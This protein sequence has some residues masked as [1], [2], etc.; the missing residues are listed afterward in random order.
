MVFIR[1]PE[2]VRQYEVNIFWFWREVLLHGD[3]EL[4]KENL[5]N[6]FLLFPVGILLPPI[7]HKKTVWWKGLLAGI[8]VSTA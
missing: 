7:L 5:L 4:L 8:I 3:R 1:V 6:F 2:T